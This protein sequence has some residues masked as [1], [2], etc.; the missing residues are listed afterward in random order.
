MDATERY[1]ILKALVYKENASGY[2]VVHRR[3]HFEDCLTCR[4]QNCKD[5]AEKCCSGITVRVARDIFKKR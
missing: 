5:A 2:Y 3:S 4:D 1:A